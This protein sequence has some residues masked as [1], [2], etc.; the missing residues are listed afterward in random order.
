MAY[1]PHVESFN[2]NLK[3]LARD[4]ARQFPADAVISRIQKRT[5][6]IIALDPLMVIDIAGPRLYAYHELIYNDGIGA[7]ATFIDYDFS[8]DI[9]S[10]EDREDSEIAAHIIPKVQHAL[11]EVSAEDQRAYWEILVNLLDDYIEYLA[12]KK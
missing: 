8:A 2:H 1:I 5:V 6:A 12:A 4:L 9:Q 7:L 11:R 10:A 3:V